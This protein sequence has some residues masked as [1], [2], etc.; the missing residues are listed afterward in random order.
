MMSQERA[1]KALAPTGT[2]RASINVGNPVLARRN[3][4]GAAPYGVSIDIA[5]ALADHLGVGIEFIVF[6]AAGQSVDAVASGRADVGFFAIDPKRGESISFTDA[7]LYIEGWYA[8]RE[9]S[10]IRDV[11]EVD[12]AG[13][14]IAVGRGSAYDLF[15]SRE[16]KQAE[17]VR[18]ANPQAV[19]PMFV[20]EQLEVVAGVKQQLEMD[21][22]RY[23]GLRL[24]PERFMVIRQA[25]GLA[26]QRGDAAYAELSSFVEQLKT[27]GFI[28]QALQRHG[29]AGA[30]LAPAGG[31]VPR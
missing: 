24:L 6:D 22:Q 7:Y 3:A 15:L 29:I 28:A 5:K 9:D 21:L 18:A 30:S 20:D 10:L 27:N 17:L 12:R 19:T 13:A 14:R 16:L 31:A 11:A 26:R 23:P 8:V 4:P 25:M 2:L 1:A